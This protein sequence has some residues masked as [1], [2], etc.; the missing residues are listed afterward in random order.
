MIFLV[1]ITFMAYHR[2]DSGAAE[3][4]VNVCDFD[5]LDELIASSNNT[6][7]EVSPPRQSPPAQHQSAAKVTI[8]TEE[9]DTVDGVESFESDEQLPVSLITAKTKIDLILSSTPD[10]L[11]D[12]EIGPPPTKPIDNRP[13]KPPKPTNL[14]KTLQEQ[15]NLITT[16]TTTD[17]VAP[18]PELTDESLDEDIVDAVNELQVDEQ[19][20]EPVVVEVPLNFICIKYILQHVGK[21]ERTNTAA[22]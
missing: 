17:P 10:E 1:N 20:V 2:T 14:G 13:I 8:T 9:V 21:G 3:L 18:T 5:E 12:I 22:G 19:V 6:S 15:D 7:V 16:T 4:N 11:D